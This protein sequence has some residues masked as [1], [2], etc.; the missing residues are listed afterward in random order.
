MTSRK[1][2]LKITSENILSL[3]NDAFIPEETTYS[4]LLKSMNDREQFIASLES[5]LSIFI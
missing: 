3:R 4:I 5:M 1:Q 2:K